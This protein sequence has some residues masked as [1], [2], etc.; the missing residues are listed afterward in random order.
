[1]RIKNQQLLFFIFNL[2]IYYFKSIL[3]HEIQSVEV[4]F[5]LGQHAHNKTLKTFKNRFILSILVR[6]Q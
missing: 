5:L 3:M 1:M 2:K 6:Q 4:L